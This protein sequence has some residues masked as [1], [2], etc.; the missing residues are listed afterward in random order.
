MDKLTSFLF[1]LHESFSVYERQQFV[2]SETGKMFE[3]NI[4]RNW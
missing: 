3:K 1:E 2:A 4:V